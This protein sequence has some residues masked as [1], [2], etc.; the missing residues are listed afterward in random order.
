MVTV[1]YTY[2]VNHVGL[3]CTL[4]NVE[5]RYLK[6]LKTKKSIQ[7]KVWYEANYRLQFVAQLAPLELEIGRRN[8]AAF[9]AKND[10]SLK[11]DDYI[12]TTEDPWLRP[13]NICVCWRHWL[14]QKLTAGKPSAGETT[15][16]RET[17]PIFK[18]YYSTELFGFFFLEEGSTSTW[19]TFFPFFTVLGWG[20]SPSTF[21]F[22]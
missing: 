3:D 6:K 12:H 10:F 20:S 4:S 17:L 7:T 15:R 13:S 18:L 22:L 8:T 19:V 2:W 5:K 11:C 1:Q 21:S 9:D 14:A 16:V